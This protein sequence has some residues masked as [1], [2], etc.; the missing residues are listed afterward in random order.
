MRAAKVEPRVYRESY[1]FC[2]GLDSTQRAVQ[3]DAGRSI[4]G[5]SL[6]DT[7]AIL[8]GLE[9]PGGPF[10]SPSKALK[11]S[12]KDEY[13]RN[14]AAIAACREALDGQP[15]DIPLQASSHP[16]AKKTTPSS[17]AALRHFESPTGNIQCLIEDGAST[18]GEVT[19]ILAR[20]D[21]RHL[22]A[23]PSDCP[24]DWFPTD[25]RLEESGKVD[26]GGCRGDIGP[27]C[28]NAND[29][30]GPCTTLEYGDA[31]ET[32]QFRCASAETG[33]TCRLRVGSR[34]GFQIAHE[35]YQILP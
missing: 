21:W 30:G 6:T 22:P 29:Y 25:M 7:E 26:I 4:G 11:S 27:A 24:T 32:R 12:V 31:I 23:E 8:V 15:P 35:G 16:R 13:V 3:A 9:Q 10:E 17:T 19:C 20:N 14:L 5:A 34:S 33:I 28:I 18:S 2:S 1:R